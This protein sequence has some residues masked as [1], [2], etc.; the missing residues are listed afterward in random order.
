MAKTLAKRQMDFRTNRK[1]EGGMRLDM[2]LPPKEAT[3]L[4]K[5][6]VWKDTRAPQF[7]LEVINNLW[8][9]EVEIAAKHGYPDAQFEYACLYARECA[10]GKGRTDESEMAKWWFL[11]CSEHYHTFT[12]ESLWYPEQKYRKSAVDNNLAMLELICGD[13]R[14]ALELLQFFWNQENKVVLYNLGLLGMEGREESPAYHQVFKWFLTSAQQEFSPAQLM[15][16]VLYAI[17]KGEPQNHEEA[18]AWLRRARGEDTLACKNFLAW[19]LSTFPHDEYGIRNGSVAVAIAE[20]LVRSSGSTTH[21][22]T[23]AAAYAEAQ[24]FEDAINTQKTVRLKIQR[25][26][27]SKERGAEVKDCERRLSSYIAKKPWRD[28]S[29]KFE[30][31]WDFGD[32]EVWPLPN[33]AHR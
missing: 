19:L 3:K 28:T 9:I 24:R 6:M 17:G 14:R 31:C 15:V 12:D 30:Y 16:G 32:N 10:L 2:W 5:L 25:G 8:E 18:L 21:L 4:R 13:E 7:F 23:L 26:R 27:P 29:L 33:L 22:N 20:R 1:A 11:V